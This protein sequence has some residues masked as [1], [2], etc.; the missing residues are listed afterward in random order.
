M[1]IFKK[2]AQ[3]WDNPGRV[4]LANEIFQ[5]FFQAVKMNSNCQIL[6]IGAGTGLITLQAAEKAGAVIA[7]DS[8]REMLDRLLEKIDRYNL[9]NIQVVL[10]VVEDL[11]IKPVDLIL[12]SMTF[13]HIENIEKTVSS[14][15]A[16]LKPGGEVAIAD[17]AE[18]DGNFHEDLAEVYHYGFNSQEL[19]K[20]FE[21][22][23]FQQIKTKMITEIQRKNNQKYPVFLLTAVK[24]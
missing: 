15:Y 14:L 18:E 11:Q 4:T 9:H 10:G 22:A 5:V 3:D 24:I 23:G 20:I 21:K 12:S 8:S 6:E 2:K 13:H 1:S 17:L 19:I 7:L 16:L